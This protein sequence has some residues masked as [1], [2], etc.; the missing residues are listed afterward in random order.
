ME[1]SRGAWPP[2]VR[3]ERHHRIGTLVGRL[4]EIFRD[5]I[6]KS[7][8]L[9]IRQG[10]ILPPLPQTSGSPQT[11]RATAVCQSLRTG[12]YNRR[13]GAPS[14]Q[15]LKPA[16]ERFAEV[17]FNEAFRTRLTAAMRRHSTALVC[18]LSLANF[19]RMISR[20]PNGFVRPQIKVLRQHKRFWAM[21]TVVVEESR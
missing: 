12:S 18:F 21:R 14:I 19:R 9:S 16:V 7:S 20:N 15:I 11:I 2:S 17:V 1:E 4:V 8:A 6:A 10:A 5:R 3:A 13:R